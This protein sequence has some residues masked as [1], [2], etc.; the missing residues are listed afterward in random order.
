MQS[1]LYNTIHCEKGHSHRVSTMDSL[2]ADSTDSL[3]R[4][5]EAPSP[6]GGEVSLKES[7]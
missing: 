3:R 4:N 7:Q 5:D 1:R 2:R 6:T